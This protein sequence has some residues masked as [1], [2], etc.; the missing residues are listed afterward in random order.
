MLDLY[1]GAGTLGIEALSRG[2]SWADFVEVHPGRCREIRKALRELGMDGR[3]RIYRAKVEGALDQVEGE[4]GLVL[5]DPPYD[6]DPWDLMMDRLQGGRL[7][8]EGALVV[9]EHSHRRE[10]AERYGRM[11]RVT[12]RRYG[13]TSVSI[14]GAGAPDG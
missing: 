5:A 3:A 6:L 8:S 1:A 14:Y 10:L 11:V 2:A 13:D 9:T 7:L 12:S 4:Y